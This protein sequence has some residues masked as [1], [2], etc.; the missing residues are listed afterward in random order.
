[1]SNLHQVDRVTSIL[2]IVIKGA[3]TLCIGEALKRILMTK[4]IENNVMRIY[5]IIM[6]RPP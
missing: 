5:S 6:K 1:M 3:T 4:E 2:Y